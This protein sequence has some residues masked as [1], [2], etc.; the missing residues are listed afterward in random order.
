MLKFLVV[1]L[2]VGWLLGQLIRYFLRS[3]LA[4]FA[5]QVNEAAMEQQRAQQRAQSKKDVNVDF[6]PREQ[7]EKRRK[8]IQGGEYIDYEEVK[9]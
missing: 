2:G 4:Q 1:L 7:E 9:E 5:K 6:I 8:D 3:K